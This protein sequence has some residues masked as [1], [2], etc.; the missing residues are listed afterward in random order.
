MKS[1]R[2]WREHHEERERVRKQAQ[3]ELKRADQRR[4]DRTRLRAEV[5]ALRS[6]FDDSQQHREVQFEAVAAVIG[7]KENEMRGHVEDAVRDLRR[8]LLREVEQM[9]ARI[10]K[11]E[12]RQSREKGEFK[13]AGE[14]DDVDMAAEPLSVPRFLPVVRKVTVN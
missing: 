14:R 11:L 4:Q 8:E 10:K 7:M 3:E 13:F 5:D 6:E 12:A 9:M 1:P 2:E